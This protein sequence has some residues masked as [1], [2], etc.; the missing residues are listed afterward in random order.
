VEL[1]AETDVAGRRVQRELTRSAA[2]RRLGS[3]P[4]G[5]VVFTDQALPAIRPVNHLV[6]NGQVVFRS[7]SGAAIVRA[8]ERGVV[9][10]YE[11][12]AID[13]EAQTGWSVVV[14]GVARLVV[15]PESVSRYQKLL[16][17]W[18]DHPM[19]QVIAISSDIVTG[20][21]LTREPAPPA[22]PAAPAG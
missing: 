10:A 12:D 4:V 21:A 7:H 9:V 11:A 15:D 8:A 3:V 17:P 20:F 19:D 2:L 13:P 22:E 18:V 16:Q 1:M 14:T 6:E 5:R